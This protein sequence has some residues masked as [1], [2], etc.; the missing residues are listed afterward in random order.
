MAYKDSKGKRWENPEMGRA[1]DRGAQRGMPTTTQGEMH[2]SERGEPDPGNP[3]PGAEEPIESVVASHG[4]ATEVE[5]H[6]KHQDGHVHKSKHH[7]PHSAKHHVSA[8]MGAHDED[9]DMG[10]GKGMEALPMA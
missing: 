9:D 4:P 7:D 10:G 8:A 2:R 6:S 3:Q 5:V 1:S